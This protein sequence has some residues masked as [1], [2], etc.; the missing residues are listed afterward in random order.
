MIFL[1]DDGY[2]ECVESFELVLLNEL[3]V[4]S[5]GS[6]TKHLPDHRPHLCHKLN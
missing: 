5:T 1:S 6:E 4:R 2:L 3:N